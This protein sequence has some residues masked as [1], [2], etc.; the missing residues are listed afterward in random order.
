MANPNIVNVTAIYGNTT[1]A[2]L[3]TTGATVLLSN[4]ASSNL[5][6]KVNNIVV[7]N[8][9]GTTAANVTVSVNSAAAGGGTAYDLAYQISVPAGASLIV[10]DKSTAFYLMENQSVVIT[11][12]TAGYLEAV[13]SYENISS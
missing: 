5:V 1:Y 10:T 9:N 12:G 4:A 6:Y 13:L 3:S 7:S 11:A 2:A 8:I